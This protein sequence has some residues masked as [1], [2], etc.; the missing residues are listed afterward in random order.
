MVSATTV[1]K[2]DRT[3]LFSELA[4]CHAA[5]VRPRLK[6]ASDRPVSVVPTRPPGKRAADSD[7]DNPGSRNLP[8]EGGSTVEDGQSRYGL[9]EVLSK[10]IQRANKTIFDMSASK[11]HCFGM[12]TTLVTAAFR[13]NS[14]TVAHVGDSRLYRKRGDSIS[15]LTTDHS[16]VQELIETG[17]YT[18]EEAK[19]SDRKNIVTRAMGIEAEVKP[20]YQELPVEPGDIYLLCSDGLTDLV[21]DDEIQ[22]ILLLHQ[23]NLGEAAKAL[24]SQA[25]E[26]GGKDNISVILARVIRPFPEVDDETYG[27]LPED[28]LLMVGLSDVGRKRSHNED[29]IDSDARFGVAILAD[30]MGGANAGEVASALA[31]KVILEDYQV[32]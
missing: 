32:E 15:Q 16:L 20:S 6:P 11:A 18:P 9:R 13:N 27:R 25:N 1:S 21:D 28:T 22:A 31:V 10:A 29:H 17:F 7:A 30:G 14:M 2:G 12:G 23:D 5:V 24:I 4:N 19:Q 8:Q 3:R 26:K